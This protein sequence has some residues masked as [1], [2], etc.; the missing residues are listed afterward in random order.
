MTM[1]MERGLAERGAYRLS[2]GTRLRDLIDLERREVSLRVFS[3]PE[4]YQ[5]ELERIFARQ[6]LWL[7]HESEIPNPGDYVLRNIGEDGVIVTRGKDGQVNVLLNVCAHRGMEVCRTDKGN[8]QAFNCP[9]HG[10]NFGIDGALLGAPYESQMYGDWDKS[11]YGLQKLAVNVRHGL[12]FGC[13]ADDP[14]PFDEFLG[15]YAW[16]LDAMFGNVEWETL[17]VRNRFVFKGNWKMRA[18][19]N[20]GDL[21]HV[22]GAHRSIAEMGQVGAA[23]G[24]EGAMD[25][26]KIHLDSGHVIF[27]MGAGRQTGRQAGDFTNAGRQPDEQAYAWDNASFSGLMFPFTKVTGGVGRTRASLDN[28]QPMGPTGFDGAMLSLVPKGAAEQ[29]K[30]AMRSATVVSGS[31]IGADDGACWESMQRGASGVLGRKITAKYNATSQPNKPDH[32]PGPGEGFAGFSKDDT[33]WC[34]WRKWYEMI[35]ADEA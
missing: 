26:L 22:A 18:D 35:T 1:T 28:M 9:Y 14:Q 4:I 31:L 23:M 13:G 25:L 16:Y 34:F 21:Y 10:W 15:E 19:Q 3:D 6:W 7:A 24:A 30:E 8:A 27:T 29:I 20:A 2:D 33:Q 5:L 11:R 17:G 12:I 32:W